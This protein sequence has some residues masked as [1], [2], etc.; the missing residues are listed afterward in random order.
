MTIIL[1]STSQ[2]RA[3]I[4]ARAGLDFATAAPRVDEEAIRDAMQ[5]DGASPRDIAD[6]LAEAKALKISDKNAQA[7]VLGC[8]QIL[9][10]G[11]VIFTKPE[12]PDHAITQLHALRGQT[13]HLYSAIVIYQNGQPMWRHIGHARLTM[14]AMSDQAL[15]SYVATEWE[16]I[17]HSVGCYKIEE[18]GIQL[19]SQIDG[20]VFTIQG[21]PLLPLLNYLAL[22]GIIAS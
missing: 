4:L 6:S 16:S 13:H 17:R 2:I 18:R 11:D 5:A 20:D 19:F 9:A 10:L 1:A 7:L 14:R 12:T 15:A 21:L 8:D 22:R 3:Q